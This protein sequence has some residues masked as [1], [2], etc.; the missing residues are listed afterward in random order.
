MRMRVAERLKGAQN[1][2]AMLSTFNEVDMTNLIAMRNKYK[3]CVCACVFCVTEGQGRRGG[4]LGYK[5]WR[6]TTIFLMI[7][8]DL[9]IWLMRVVGEIDMRFT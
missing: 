4:F 2:Y 6:R 9:V 7:L 5:V 3:V 1:T 8:S